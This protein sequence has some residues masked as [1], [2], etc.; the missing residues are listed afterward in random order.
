MKRLNLSLL[1]ASML[2]A[3]SA[4]GGQSQATA[5]LGTA[6]YEYDDEGWPSYN[7]QFLDLGYSYGI[8]DFYL[9][10]NAMLGITEGEGDIVDTPSTFSRNQYSV[11]IGYRFTLRVSMFT[12]VN[13]AKS[14]QTIDY[15]FDSNKW[16]ITELGYHLGVAGSMLYF[17]G[18][19]SLN[20]KLAYSF[21]NTFEVDDY[22]AD[23][24]GIV[25][26][27]GWTGFISRS[28]GYYVNVDGYSY[29]YTDDNDEDT[30]SDLLSLKAGV[31][32]NF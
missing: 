13:Y 12:G 16:D 23:G 5:G 15:G 32:Y 19:G 22:K 18:V 8:S 30:K 29:G 10:L 14:E 28:L 24:S 20:G 2:F 17:E 27:L 31:S 11:N 25:F 26:G 6:A 9:N 4:L 21:A 1:A 7:Y 3:V